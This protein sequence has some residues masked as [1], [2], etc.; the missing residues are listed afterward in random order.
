MAYALKNTVSQSHSLEKRR[1]KATIPTSLMTLPSELRNRIC[2]FIF[3]IPHQQDEDPANLSNDHLS[4]RFNLLLCSRQ[5]RREQFEK[6]FAVDR[7]FQDFEALNAWICKGDALNPDLLPHVRHVGIQTGRTR[8]RNECST[9]YH[10]LHIRT[11]FSRLPGLRTLHISS[12]FTLKSFVMNNEEVSG[13]MDSISEACPNLERL[14]FLVPSENL[15]FLHNLPNLHFLA[16][17]TP[18]FFDAEHFLSAMSALPGL[19]AFRIRDKSCS[20][21]FTPS[22]LG[23][24]PPLKEIQLKDD[25]AHGRVVVPAMMGA[26]LDRHGATV[27]SLHLEI[28][29]SAKAGTLNSIFATLP[30]LPRLSI[31]KLW[32]DPDRR[33]KEA[34]E[35]L[36]LSLSLLLRL[37]DLHLCFRFPKDVGSAL[38]FQEIMKALQATGSGSWF[39][40]YWVN[41]DGYVMDDGHSGWDQDHSHFFKYLVPTFQNSI[42]FIVDQSVLPTPSANDDWEQLSEKTNLRPIPPSPH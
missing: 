3:E 19:S 33:E 15:N 14:A 11:A 35:T 22:I 32:Y 27:T 39:G 21:A 8:R 30:Q 26:L 40:E 38:A 36:T 7:F 2:D 42:L 31:L 1:V 34:L 10:G 23:Q 37:E 13:I 25:M 9:A 20:L 18:T 12:P 17:A 24:M 28:S 16:I 29:R 4:E 5:L 41:E 6:L